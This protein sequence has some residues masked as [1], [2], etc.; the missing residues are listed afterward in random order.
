MFAPRYFAPSY[1][2]P[3]YFPPGAEL[4]AEEVAGDYPDARRVPKT[5]THVERTI[6]G[7]TYL[8]V[9]LDYGDYIVR[10]LLSVT[11]TDLLAIRQ[12][13]TDSQ[14]DAIR[15]LEAKEEALTL[16][17]DA[18]PL[19]LFDATLTYTDLTALDTMAARQ[20]FERVVDWELR[21]AIA[22]MIEMEDFLLTLVLIDDDD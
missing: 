15:Q 3:S 13:D 2:A 17:Q 21:N 6:D 5:I 9:I 1:F 22:S 18:P 19:G 16:G 4:I 11:Q 12:A 7:K 14:L 8:E 10:Q 20:L